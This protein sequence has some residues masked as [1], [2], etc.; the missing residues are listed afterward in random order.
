MFGEGDDEG[1]DGADA[2][3]ARQP[4]EKEGSNHPSAISIAIL[5][6]CSLP[7]PVRPKSITL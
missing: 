4:V 6:M 5:L 1:D 2:G 3:T 7:V